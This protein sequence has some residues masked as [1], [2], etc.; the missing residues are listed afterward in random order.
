M[1]EFANVNVVP[2]TAATVCDPSNGEPTPA[3]VTVSPGSSPAVDPVVSVAV[4]DC[5]CFLVMPN[6]NGGGW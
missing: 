5:S 2:V 4:P 6:V 1:A 3:M